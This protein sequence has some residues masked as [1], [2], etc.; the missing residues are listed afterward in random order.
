MKGNRRDAEVH[1]ADV[2][3]LLLESMKA[4]NGGFGKR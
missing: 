2:E 3:L 4:F 1:G